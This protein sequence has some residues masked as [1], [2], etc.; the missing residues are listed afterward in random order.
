MIEL[1]AIGIVLYFIVLT[2]SAPNVFI[3]NPDGFMECE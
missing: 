2:N 3:D 1:S